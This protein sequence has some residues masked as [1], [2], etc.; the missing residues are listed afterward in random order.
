MEDD[1]DYQ[2]WYDD[3][4]PLCMEEQ[5]IWDVIADNVESDYHITGDEWAYERG[6]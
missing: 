1:L 4:M 3:S 6:E 5:I 2:E